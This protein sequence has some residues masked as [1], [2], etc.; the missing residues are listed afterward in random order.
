MGFLMKFL[1]YFFMT[2]FFAFLAIHSGFNQE[3]TKAALLGSGTVLWAIF[4]IIEGVRNCL[5]ER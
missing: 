5:R 2:G 1:R 4:A 3:A